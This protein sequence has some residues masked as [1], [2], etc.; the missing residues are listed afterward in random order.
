MSSRGFFGC[1]NKKD[2]FVWTLLSTRNFC[3]FTLEKKIQ[4]EF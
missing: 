4:K 3:E 2:Q 1:R